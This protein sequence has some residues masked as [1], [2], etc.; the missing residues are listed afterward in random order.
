MNSIE[1]EVHS[2]NTNRDLNY[3]LYVQ[4]TSGFTR[5]PYQSEL[6]KYM[7]ISSGDVEG[8]RRNFEEMRQNFQKGTGTLSDD[9]LRNLMYHF[10][11]AAAMV[12]RTC[13]ECGMGHDEA[14][15]LSD[16]YIRKGDVCT[17]YEKLM[18]LF[19]EML[20]DYAGRM[21]EIRKTNVISIHIRRCI[22]Y[23]YDH[24][25]ENLTVKFLAEYAGLHPSYLSKLFLQETGVTV[26][27]FVTRAKITTAENLLKYSDFS[28]LDIALGLGFSSQSAFISVFRKVN[29]MTPKKYREM[30]DT[31]LPMGRRNDTESLETGSV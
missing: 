29:G 11:V 9:P 21:R 14:Y 2:M 31:N 4:K 19:G 10:V 16:I 5:T 30:F 6:E 27:E 22:D 12:S 28:Y 26:K 24:L 17:S 18:D 3:R 1:Q 7:V 20:V 13:V 25:G 15:T 23:I 8:A